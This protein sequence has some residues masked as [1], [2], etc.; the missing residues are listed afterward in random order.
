MSLSLTWQGR[1]ITHPALRFLA[2]LALGVGMI[3][4]VTALALMVVVIVF[5]IPIWLPLDFLL[6]KLGRRGF[7][8][9]NGDGTFSVKLSPGGFS[10]A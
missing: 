8:I 4:L 5:T 10:H 2:A 3:L 9:A 1:E 7:I 6:R